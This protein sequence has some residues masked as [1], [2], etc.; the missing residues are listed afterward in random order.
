MLPVD[1]GITITSTP[2]SNGT[3]VPL[4]IGEATEPVQ[5]F[6][7][8]VS[9]RDAS[10]AKVARRPELPAAHLWI[11]SQQDASES[12]DMRRADRRRLKALGYIVD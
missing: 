4:L 5:I 3:P 9:I 10:A 6:P 8:D 7:H 1:A 11:E 2:V 12:V